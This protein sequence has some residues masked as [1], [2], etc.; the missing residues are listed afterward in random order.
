LGLDAKLS[1]M[2]VGVGLKKREMEWEEV[3]RREK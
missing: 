1:M 2:E 3:V